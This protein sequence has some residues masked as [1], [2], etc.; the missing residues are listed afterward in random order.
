MGVCTDNK[1][2]GYALGTEVEIRGV[3]CIVGS[4]T[5]ET[6]FLENTLKH[7]PL[8]YLYT[9]IMEMNSMKNKIEVKISG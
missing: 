9:Y 8:I 1:I 3:G 7:N 4:E 5:L 6:L 2:L